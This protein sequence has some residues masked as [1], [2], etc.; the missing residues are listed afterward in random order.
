MKLGPRKVF[1]TCIWSTFVLLVF[2]VILG[3]LD[4]LVSKWSLTR[5]RRAVERN[6]VKFG[7]RLVVVTCICAIF[8]LLVFRVIWRT[9]LKMANS[10]TAGNRAKRSEIWYSHVIAYV[11][12]VPFGV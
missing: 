5:K 9:C 8:D 4:A 7:T 10:K 3:S 6:G 11:Y 2:K 1:V 12:G